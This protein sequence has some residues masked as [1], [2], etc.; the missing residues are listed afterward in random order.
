MEEYTDTVNKGIIPIF[1]GHLLNEEDLV[2]RQHI[3]NIM[4]HFETSWENEGLQFPEL[5]GCLNSLKE[6]END[7]LIKLGDRNLIVHD[8]ARGFVRNVCMAFDLRL[9]RKKLNE[10]MFSMTI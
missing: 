2:I 1:R 4:C 3:L 7:L 6:M 5:G 9:R 10:R 8:E